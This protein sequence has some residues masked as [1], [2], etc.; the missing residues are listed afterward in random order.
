N[1]ISTP[2]Q[3]TPPTTPHWV[4]DGLAPAPRSGPL[5]AEADIENNRSKSFQVFRDGLR[6]LVKEGN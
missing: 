1:K 5:R 6:R 2:H 4:H 3:K